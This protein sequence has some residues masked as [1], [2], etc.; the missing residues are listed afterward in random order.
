[1]NDPIDKMPFFARLLLFKECI[2]MH[3]T[4]M[5]NS[6]WKYTDLAKS[7]NNGLFKD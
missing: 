3:F 2:P 4:R 7:S 5:N 1:M 6:S